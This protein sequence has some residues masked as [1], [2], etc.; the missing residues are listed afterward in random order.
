MRPNYG[1][2]QLASMGPRRFGR[3]DQENMLKRVVARMLQWGRVVSDA[4]M[5][6]AIRPLVKADVASMGPRR[7]GR[8]D[9][10]I[11]NASRCRR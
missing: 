3:G 11:T 9:T 4:V 5:L 2:A 8:G 6:P 7:F 10:R 1:Q